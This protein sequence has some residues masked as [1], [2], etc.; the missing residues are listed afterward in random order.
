MK[1]WNFTFIDITDETGDLGW[2]TV[3]ARGRKSAIKKAEKKLRGFNKNYRLNPES[4]ST[5]EY[6][7]RM[8]AMNFD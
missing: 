1:E 5:S 7:H 2:H 4:L 8:L 6:N 3:M